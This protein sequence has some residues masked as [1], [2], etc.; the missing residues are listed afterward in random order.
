M[1]DSI[2]PYGNRILSGAYIREA[3]HRCFDCIQYSASIQF[4][5]A[6]YL[7]QSEA[8][9]VCIYLA[10]FIVAAD[11]QNNRSLPPN[12]KIHRISDAA[13]PAMG[14]LRRVLKLFHL[15]FK[16]EKILFNSHFDHIVPP[17]FKQII[18]L[19]NMLKRI[20]M[21]NQRRCINFSHTYPAAAISAPR[22]TRPL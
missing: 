19:C 20:C 22:H 17:V 14:S 8:I 12:I 5:L 18:G 15:A 9:P 6:D 16:L 3:K 13:I 1:D 10:D 2:Y 7:F 4:F 11:S 21:G